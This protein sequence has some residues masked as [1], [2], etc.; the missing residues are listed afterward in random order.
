MGN[1]TNECLGNLISVGENGNSDNNKY[2]DCSVLKEEDKKGEKEEIRILAK[3]DFS[4]KN[5]L[6]VDEFVK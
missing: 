1:D 3:E 6:L 2:L 5:D 4:I